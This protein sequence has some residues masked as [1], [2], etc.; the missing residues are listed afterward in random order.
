MKLPKIPYTMDKDQS[1]QIPFRGINYSD[2]L[3]DGDVAD[4]RGI[5]MRRYPFI[6]TRRG[7]ELNAD[8]SNK[9]TDT[10][11]PYNGE[12][13]SVRDGVLYKGKDSTGHTVGNGAKF[14]KINSKLVSF[15][16]TEKVFYD[17]AD[18]NKPVSGELEAEVEAQSVTFK[19]NG[20]EVG[21][22]KIE[23]ASGLGGTFDA[24]NK[25]FS[26]NATEKIELSGEW[27][28]SGYSAWH[29]IHVSDTFKWD[30]KSNEYYCYEWTFVNDDNIVSKLDENIE[31]IVAYFDEDGN[32]VNQ[33]HLEYSDIETTQDS[34]VIM[35]KNSVYLLD[36]LK[37]CLYISCAPDYDLN[38]KIREGLSVCLDGSEAKNEITAVDT[39]HFYA[40]DESGSYITF[41]GHFKNGLNVTATSTWEADLTTLVGVRDTIK[42]VGSKNN[43]KSY[44]IESVTQ[45]LSLIHI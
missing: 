40:K 18:K 31:V 12:L 8:A 13:A 11:F 44:V 6:T 2:M 37:K 43:T 10:I 16:D 14:A 41:Y 5:S 20:L 45:D 17:T 34:I 36:N 23:G 35:L 15:S 9:D 3:T 7:R 39:N 27:L 25:S 28:V 4:S 33:N 26:R 32:Y 38:N 22:S 29:V 42:F 19:K 1:V 21:F 30:Y 24:A